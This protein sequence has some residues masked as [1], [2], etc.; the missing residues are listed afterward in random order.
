MK[1]KCETG[2]LHDC[3]WIPLEIPGFKLFVLGV[4]SFQ[5]MCGVSVATLGCHELQNSWLYGHGLAE[6]D[7]R[8]LKII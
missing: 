3:P 2:E 5:S 6:L 7:Y 4:L 1:N 8:C